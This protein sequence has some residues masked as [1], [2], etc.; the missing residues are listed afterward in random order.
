MKNFDIA[1]LGSGA[2]GCMCAI[3]A[4]QSGKTIALID[5]NKL[6]AKKLMATGN[7]RCNLTN[8]H[9][10]NS[11]KF[12]NHNLDDFFYL[13]NSAD[14][15][16]FFNELGLVVYSD[17]E[18][19]VYPISNSAKSVVDVINNKLKKMTN[20][21]LF[22]EKTIKKVEKMGKKF[23]ISLEDE[24][25]IAEKI[26]F[27][28]GG[29][30]NEMLKTLGVKC[31]ENTPSLC[32]LKTKELLK[33]LSSI[34]LSP[35]LVTA[36]SDK[37]TTFSEQGEVMF[38]E[39][40]LSGIVIFNASTLFA[41]EGNFKGKIIL[42]LMPSLSEEKL[43]KL[44][45]KRKT[46]NVKISN[47]F[48]GMFAN[49]LSYYLLEKCKINEERSSLQLNQK[50]I[51][52]LAKAIKCLEFE[53]IAPLDNNQVFSGGALLEDLNENLQSK[54]CRNLFI[55]G[56]ACDVDGMCGGYNLQWAWTSGFIV[57]KSLL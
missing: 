29:N 51:E 9:D 48:D 8:I 34:R 19:R 2:S 33:L 32:G 15:L 1:I 40:G 49:G 36:I 41:R 5:K 47:F 54:S 55:C 46:L 25:I 50:E 21:S 57:G 23:K 4:G 7:G 56:E 27:S 24:E 53:I 3:T 39:N 18:G 22:S 17:E 52:L 6:P 43:K 42:D 16:K 11:E 30:S 37:G 13:F 44:L 20:I 28:L 10:N 14:T 12:Y 45:L 38:K 31:K 35:V 26:V